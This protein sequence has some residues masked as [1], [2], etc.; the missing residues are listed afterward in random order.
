MNFVAATEQRHDNEEQ[1]TILEIPKVSY[2]FHNSSLNYQNPLK[3]ETSNF[4][5]FPPISIFPPII[6]SPL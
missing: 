4:I 2:Q 6:V 1:I 3:Q 5:N